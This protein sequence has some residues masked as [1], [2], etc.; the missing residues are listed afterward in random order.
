MAD[1]RLSCYL[2]GPKPE[3]Y[4]Y[5]KTPLLPDNWSYIAL[6]YDGE[7]L[8]FYINGK[9]DNEI[10]LGGKFKPCLDRI[11]N[12]EYQKASLYFGYDPLSPG[13]KYWNGSLDEVRILSRVLLNGEIKADYERRT[14]ARSEPRVTIGEEKTSVN[15]KD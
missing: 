14:Y 11:H 8:R 7:K 9:L 6:I 3:D 2:Y 12:I 5:S 13:V 1:G 10:T 4:Y 15:P